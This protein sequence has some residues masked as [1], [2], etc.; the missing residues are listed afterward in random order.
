MNARIE[1]RYRFSVVQD[2]VA[3]EALPAVG[4]LVEG[5]EFVGREPILRTLC[6][7]LANRERFYI[8][9][10]RWTGKTSLMREALRRMRVEQG[11]LTAGVD[12]FPDGQ[13]RGLRGEAGRCGA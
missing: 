13:P 4:E 6:D 2:L 3:I 8:A 12:P 10:P 11:W 5:G 1:L 9:A 7:R